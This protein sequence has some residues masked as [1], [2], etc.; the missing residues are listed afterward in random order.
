[1]KEEKISEQNPENINKETTNY[2]EEIQKLKDSYLRLQAEFANYMRRNETIAE[3]SFRSGA[4]KVL[5][6][7]VDAYDDFDLALANKNCSFE[8]FKKGMELI[9]SK[10]HSIGEDFGLEIIP[11]V[12]N[13]FNPKLHEALLAEKSDKEENQVIEELQKGYMVDGMVLR[14]SKVKVAR[15]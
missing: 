5:L 14:S 3:D 13:Q 10:L 15:K 8:D 11:C 12:G 1:M 9:Y 2:Q 6:R 7:L 4:N